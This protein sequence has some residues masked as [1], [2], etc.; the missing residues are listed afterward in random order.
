M[1]QFCTYGSVRGALGNRRPYRDKSPF[2]FTDS[3]RGRLPYT[4]YQHYS[5]VALFL[6]HGR[7]NGVAQVH[8]AAAFAHVVDVPGRDLYLDVAFHHALAT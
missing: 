3:R 4:G 6:A 5:C 2:T 8:R 1:Q 7:W